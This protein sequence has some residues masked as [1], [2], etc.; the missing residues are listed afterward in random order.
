LG[1]ALGSLLSQRSKIDAWSVGG[2]QLMLAALGLLSWHG[3]MG[4]PLGALKFIAIAFVAGGLMGHSLARLEVKKTGFVGLGALLGTLLGT[5]WA[6][7]RLG[8]EIALQFGSTLAVLAFWA[9]AA[10][11]FSGGFSPTRVVSVLLGA[12]AL[13]L[14]WLAPKAPTA[15]EVQSA[16]HKDGLR[17]SLRIGF[18]GPDLLAL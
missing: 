2:Y 5:Q 7:P 14:I 13:P 16:Y 4:G 12:V 18:T 11:N 9:A 15:A 1:A 6:V 3:I 8:T 17:A 10:L